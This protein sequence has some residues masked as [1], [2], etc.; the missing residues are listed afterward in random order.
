MPSRRFLRFHVAHLHASTSRTDGLERDPHRS[1]LAECAVIDRGA[2]A[3]TVRAPQ[4]VRLP[5]QRNPFYF[6]SSP[7]V[8]VTLSIVMADVAAHEFAISQ[9]ENCTAE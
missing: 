2:Q 1:E 8:L 5:L 4:L 9:I 3:Q 7:K 6:A